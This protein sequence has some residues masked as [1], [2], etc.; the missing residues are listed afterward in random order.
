MF[1]RVCSSYIQMPARQSI[2]YSVEIT[3][4]RLETANSGLSTAI[5]QDLLW[6][7]I[8][9]VVKNRI[10]GSLVDI[11]Q[12]QRDVEFLHQSCQLIV[13]TVNLHNKISFYSQQKS[14]NELVRT[15]SLPPASFT[16]LTGRILAETRELELETNQNAMP[17]N[18]CNCRKMD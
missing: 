13:C 18:K 3:F 9:I 12:L 6:S 4:K 7:P 2:V 16:R 17:L 8:I 15:N 11:K 14:G 1:A 5:F 10:L